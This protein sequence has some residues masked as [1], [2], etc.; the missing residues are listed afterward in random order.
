MANQIPFAT[1]TTAA[2]GALV[3]PE[4]AEIMQQAIAR[5]NPAMNLVNVVR[6]NMASNQVTWPIYLGRATAGFVGEGNDKPITGGEFTTHNLFIK[7]MATN[8]VFTEEIL[9]DAYQNP[10]AIVSEDVESAFANLTD[11]HI[12]G[13]HPGAANTQA[14]L[15]TSFDG[16]N[17]GANQLALGNTTQTVEL[18][19][20]Q[21][22]FAVA[23][24]SAIATIEGNGGMPNGF[25]GA[26]DLKGHLRDA[27]DTQGRPLYTDGFANTTPSVY[28]LSAQFTTSLDG[29]P[30]G[31]QG[32]AGSK[33]KI[34]GIVG[35]FRFAKAVVRKQLVV[36]KSREATVGSHNAFEENKL[37]TQ[38]DFRM[39]F[40]VYDRDRMFVAIIN[41]A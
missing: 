28:G 14:Y 16:V 34:V 37:I 30:A 32:G 26:L 5:L 22:A 3:R 7:K 24:S 12:I 33:P 17:T 11:Q 19:T 6:R 18:G 25:L 39:G 4:Y 41:A 29:F 10:E 21:D 8:V 38:W 13:T 35:D 1:G 15:D 20:G 40:T 36:R 9:E 23:L 27:R 31:V 2:G